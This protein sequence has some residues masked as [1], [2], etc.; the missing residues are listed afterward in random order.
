MGLAT[1]PPAPAECVD[2]SATAGKDAL[3]EDESYI[4]QLTMRAQEHEREDVLK[5]RNHKSSSKCH[6]KQ[7]KT[8]PYFAFHP[9]AKLM[10]VLDSKVLICRSLRPTQ[11]W[12]F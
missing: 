6:G 3:A 12:T 11:S 2:T 8:P 4:A 1:E 9:K 10:M 7:L 5:V